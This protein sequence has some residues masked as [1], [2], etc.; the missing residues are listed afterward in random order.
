VNPDL[1]RLMGF[2][3]FKSNK[4]EPATAAEKKAQQFDIEVNKY[5]YCL[6]FKKL[7]FNDVARFWF[8]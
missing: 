4:K 1:E 8:D 7:L 5:L 3:G 6:I 2:S